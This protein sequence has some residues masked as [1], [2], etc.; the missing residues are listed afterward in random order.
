MVET[1]DLHIF[2][3]SVDALKIGDTIINY[4]IAVE[5]CMRSSHDA[6]HHNV[7]NTTDRLVL[8]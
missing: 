8:G 5:L 3:V 1:E 7:D 6:F 2:K 4:I